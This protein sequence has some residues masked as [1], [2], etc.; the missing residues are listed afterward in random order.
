MK[1]LTK[2]SKKNNLPIIE[3][4]ENPKKRRKDDQ[5]RLVEA[6]YDTMKELLTIDQINTNDVKN[7]S[8]LDA[9]RD[10]NGIWYKISTTYNHPRILSETDLFKEA[11]RLAKA[12]RVNHS[13]RPYQTKVKE[14]FERSVSSFPNYK[15]F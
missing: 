8:F 15:L 7:K 3:V 14:L 10:T 6:I 12:Y 1:L 13:M 9:T 4:P 5:A 11:K 2:R